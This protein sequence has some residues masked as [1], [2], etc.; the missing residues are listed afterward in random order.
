MGVKMCPYRRWEED[1]ERM[2]LPPVVR[3]GPLRV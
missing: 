1:R 2:P 3:N